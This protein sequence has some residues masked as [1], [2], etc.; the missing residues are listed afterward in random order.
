MLE[1][2]LSLSPRNDSIHPKPMML[3]IIKSNHIRKKHH[4]LSQLP[5][6][7][8]CAELLRNKLLSTSHEATMLFCFELTGTIST[9]TLEK[10]FS[11]S[12]LDAVLEV[13]NI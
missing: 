4:K 5:G 1:V 11:I 9:T 2:L 8:N 3:L 7:N 12:F 10:G 13:S 6:F